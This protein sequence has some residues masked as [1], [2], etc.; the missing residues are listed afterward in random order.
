MA[1]VNM[2][3]TQ[4][5]EMRE[6]AMWWSRR[7]AAPKQMS[8]MAAGGAM[9]DAPS[10]EDIE[11]GAAMENRMY[12]WQP[13]AE[14]EENT[15]LTGT[16][17][18]T[19]GRLFSGFMLLRAGRSA[20]QYY[21][22]NA[23]ISA[24]QFEA[25]NMPRRTESERLRADRALVSA[26]QRA[27][28]VTTGFLPF[29]SSLFSAQTGG[30]GTQQSAFSLYSQNAKAAENTLSYA[31]IDLSNQQA[32]TDKENLDAAREKVSLENQIYEARR[33][34]NTADA[35]HLE[36]L[37][38]IN[39]KTKQM[40]DRDPGSGTT[41]FNTVGQQMLG[42]QANDAAIGKLDTDR[43]K[44]MDF[45]TQME[46]YK[47]IASGDVRGADRELFVKEQFDKYAA[48][49]KT[50]EIESNQHFGDVAAAVTGAQK[51]INDPNATPAAKESA[52]EL[53]NQ[54]QLSTAAIGAYDAQHH[55]MAFTSGMETWRRMQTAG[56]GSAPGD[57]SGAR[58]VYAAAGGS[59][60]G[61]PLS[62]G[63]PS[64]ANWGSGPLMGEP[65]AA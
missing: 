55:G 18:G 45:A 41:W 40:N 8:G 21:E 20:E 17:M 19:M 3:M 37:E 62:L 5:E 44:R 34:G 65:V 33:K 60:A 61:N 25:E 1:D 38:K 63:S 12:P 30:P 56:Y 54:A 51:T 52:H 47:K 64:A 46:V 16:G 57:N 13:P 39:D 31:Q 29:L 59:S 7:L 49:E 24:R 26:D 2:G 28:D 53:V 10:M 48:A 42:D 50:Y 9:A 4:G 35:E 27:L 23:D 14:A 32:N 6:R 11:E 36:L 58:R 22:Q 15:F 43:I